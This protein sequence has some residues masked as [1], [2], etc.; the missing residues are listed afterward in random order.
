[1]VAQKVLNIP[2]FD[3]FPKKT[4]YLDLYSQAE[5]ERGGGTLQFPL[6]S[7]RYG[8]DSTHLCLILAGQ[9]EKRCA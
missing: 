1:M 9:E 8:Y 2:I 3:P 7:A 4:Q 5:L 6:P